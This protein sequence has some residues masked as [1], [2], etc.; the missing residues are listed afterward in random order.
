M[1]QH[2]VKFDV[3]V[4]SEFRIETRILEHNADLLAHL[5]WVLCRVKTIDLYRPAG[6]GKQSG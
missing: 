3:L 2:T 6:W 4:S 5:I 1:I